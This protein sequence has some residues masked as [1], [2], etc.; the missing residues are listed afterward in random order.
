MTCCCSHVC[1]ATARQFSEKRA[2]A[3]LRQYRAKGPG[4]TSRL[5]LAGLAKA[6]PPS[7]RLLDIGA[8]IGTVTFELLK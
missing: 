7:G 5:L 4:R 1:D 8:G 6:G 2:E 3:D